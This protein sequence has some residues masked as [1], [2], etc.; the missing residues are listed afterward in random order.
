[1]V[2]VIYMHSSSFQ[3]HEN[4]PPVRHSLARQ[5]GKIPATLSTNHLPHYS[6]STDKTPRLRREVHS[7]PGRPRVDTGGSS[8][9]EAEAASCWLQ[10]VLA[11][12]GPVAGAGRS[13]DN[14]ELAKGVVAVAGRG[15]T[16]VV[17]VTAVAVAAGDTVM[18]R[19]RRGFGL[20]GMMEVVEVGIQVVLLVREEHSCS[21]AAL[22]AC[23]RSGACQRASRSGL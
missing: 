4:Y 1:M 12:H 20:V 13:R 22:R 19:A 21:L 23:E 16:G 6:P 3:G 9:A 2:Y 11:A 10:E 17:L 5:G 15:R 7:G 18:R 8:A 14:P